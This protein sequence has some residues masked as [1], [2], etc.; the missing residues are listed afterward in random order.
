MTAAVGLM[1]ATLLIATTGCLASKRGDASTEGGTFVYAMSNEA[2]SLDPTYTTDMQSGLVGTQILETLVGLKPG[3]VE[4]EPLLATDWETS[5]DGKSWTF[6]LREG[7]K[8]HD[9]EPFDAAA[10]CYNFDRWYHLPESA[11][12][13]ENAYYYGYFFG[14]FATGETSEN[15]LYDSC[16]AVSDT[17]AV[18][19]LTRPMATF[20]SVL[21]MP[22]FA[23]HS[24][25]ALEKYQDDAAEQP[26][27][28]E[29]ATAHPT[30]T[31]PFE[32]VSWER[33]KQVTLER[34]DGYWGDRAKVSRLIMQ[35]MTDDQQRIAALR[36]D[37]VNGADNIPPTA[38]RSLEENGRKIVARPPFTLA[39]LGMNQAD[40]LLSDLKVR[41]AIAHAVDRQAIISATMPEGTTEAN[42]W[43]PDTMTG[44][45]PDVT[46][47]EYDPDEA[48]ELLA[49]AGASGETVELLYASSAS[50]ACLPST[51]DT[52]NVIRQQLEAIGLNVE[53]VS[54]P[55]SEFSSRLYGGADHQ[56]HLSCWIGQVDVPDSFVGLGFGFESPEFGF[57][58]PQFFADAQAAAQIGDPGELARTYEEL[59]DRLM[60]SLVGVPFASA[61]S[62]IG[63]SS[64]VE[65]FEASPVSAEIFRT[66]S[67]Q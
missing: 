3:T 56:L 2:L 25:R 36:N 46:E 30:G 10:V 58:D 9:G 51:E 29:Y 13:S 52:L 20:A 6:E 45:N 41:Q 38:V 57:D 14:G 61:G 22:Q 49:D 34:F 26:G 44:W 40:P 28:T 48:R 15:A 16:E 8:F 18:L 17:E 55:R 21:T 65:G 5:E 42:Q 7:V 64:D 35:V 54:L 63:L 24:P 43:V 11:Q 27:L 31:G 19:H 59:N 4:T 60:R 12:S 37:E 50:S 39:F 33:G 32:F 23:I 53:P 67:Y 66:V 1:S 47:Y 62:Y